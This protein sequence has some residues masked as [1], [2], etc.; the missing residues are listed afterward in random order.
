MGNF[1]ELIIIIIFLSICLEFY[2]TFNNNKK[3]IL[4][5]N[6]CDT[7]IE[8][9][10]EYDEDTIEYFYKILQKYNEQ[11]FNNK[12][13]KFN[14]YQQHNIFIKDTIKNHEFMKFMKNN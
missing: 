9:D 7:N 6:L 4:I 11:Q 13:R 2:K 5:N 10:N 12:R 3:N 14:E 8:A 1:I